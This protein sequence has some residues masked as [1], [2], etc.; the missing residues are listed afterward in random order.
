MGSL[1]SLWKRNLALAE[2]LWGQ[3]FNELGDTGTILPL[4][5]LGADGAPNATS[6]TTRRR[7]SSGLEAVFTWDSALTTAEF[8]PTNPAFWKGII[9][10]LTF[11]GS[12][13]EADSPDAA[14]WTRD[15]AGG[16]NGFSIGLWVKVTDT[17]NHRYLLT[18]WDD[19]E[20]IQEWILRVD[21][22][23]LLEFV[24]RDDSAGAN[25]TRTSDAAIAQGEWLFVTLTYDGT[26]GATAMSGATLYVNGASIAST[27][28][29]D[30]SYV[31]MEDGTSVVGLGAGNTGSTP[32]RHFQGEMAGGSLGPFTTQ[33]EL[34]AAQV[35]NLY[36]IGRAA[37]GID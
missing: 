23:D 20:A 15:D 3:V 9:P 26:G 28:N 30:A 36:N 34:T 1:D 37:L 29:E 19:G 32:N 5:G 13:I 27:A 11:D 35:K 16:A 8:D 2:P 22:A 33:V 17:A 12:A 10:V 31:G 25:P 14:Y 18:K 24:A 6:F 4:V 21:H 7:H